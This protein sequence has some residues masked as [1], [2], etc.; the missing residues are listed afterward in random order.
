MKKI[1]EPIII[2]SIISLHIKISC[3]EVAHNENHFFKAHTQCINTTVFSSHEII[4]IN[5]SIEK[6]KESIFAII[7][8]PHLKH[9]QIFPS[10]ML[11]LESDKENDE[12]LAH[13]LIKHKIGFKPLFMGG[14]N[15]FCFTKA[16][17]VLDITNTLFKCRVTDITQA[18][19][20][21]VI[22]NDA[23]IL[24]SV[25]TIRH[26]HVP[27]KTQRNLFTLGVTASLLGLFVYKKLW[28]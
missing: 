28:Q 6:Q 7:R 15:Y 8:R 18:D 12:H 10:D 1:I 16:H 20:S 17:V 27:N 24:Y 21:L 5:Q 19:L 13:T 25:K 22:T 2:L 3:V 4:R 9:S 26:Y 14:L 23:N 11:D